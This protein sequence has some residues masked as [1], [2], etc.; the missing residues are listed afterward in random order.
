MIDPAVSPPRLTRLQVDALVALG[1]NP[2]EPVDA[3]VLSELHGIGAA[4]HGHVHPDLLGL[5]AVLRASRATFHVRRWRQG[6]RTHLTGALGAAGYVTLVGSAAADQPVVV[7]HRSRPSALA[8]GLARFVG[9]GPSLHADEIIPAHPLEW[10]EVL[11]AAGSDPPAWVPRG[12]GPTAVPTLW[13]LSWTPHGAPRP[14]A[15]LIVLDLGGRGCAEVVPAD[16]QS[17]RLGLRPR[18]PESLWWALCRLTRA[19][20]PS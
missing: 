16:T 6:E 2:P 19:R 5:S 12:A 15:A 3:A 9:L 18:R 8:R 20:S 10:A 13:D 14:T 1:A 7:A 17:G 11:A 4:S